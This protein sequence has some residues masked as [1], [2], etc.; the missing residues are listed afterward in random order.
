M[1]LIKHK[2][3]LL[4]SVGKVIENYPDYLAITCKTLTAEKTANKLIERY[5]IRF[6]K[7]GRQ[8]R[9]WLRKNGKASYRL[10]AYS[11]IDEQVVLIVL[12]S[13]GEAVEDNEAWSNAYKQP[14]SLLGYELV[15]MTRPEQEKPAW[16]WRLTQQRKT[17][18]LSEAKK[19]INDKEPDR[20]I[21]HMKKVFK[22]CGFAGVRKDIKEINQAV[23]AHWQRTMKDKTPLPNGYPDKHGYLR[24]MKVE[25]YPLSDLV[26]KLTS[27]AK[28][29]KKGV[30]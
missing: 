4:Q 6:D 18:F 17:G 9:L 23:L 13:D 25:T 24:A 21:K 11:P 1:D 3:V 7:A 12:K 30:R 20:L 2:S 19:H 28:N 5:G 14:L 16:T 10:F 8:H 15:R 22:S 26:N 27:S 29:K